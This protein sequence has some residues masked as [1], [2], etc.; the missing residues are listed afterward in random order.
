MTTLATQ[1]GCKLGVIG[2]GHWGKN[3]IRNAHQ[4]GVLVAICD[5]RPN[6]ALQADYPKAA[7]YTDWRDLLHHNRLDAVMIA[8]PSHTHFDIASQSLMLGKHVYV[9]KPMTTHSADAEALLALSEQENRVLMVGH[10]LMYH[11]AV[12]RLKQ[13]IK[14]GE[15]GDIRA[16]QSDRLS[17]NPN[18]PDASV[19]WDLAP[20]DISLVHYLLDDDQMTVDHVSGY[21]IGGDGRYDDVTVMMTLPASGAKAVIHTSW[22]HPAKQVQLI[23]HGTKASAVLNDTLTHDK[24]LLRYHNTQSQPVLDTPDCLSL[25][26]L[27]VECQHFIACVANN[28]TP[29]THAT[30]GLAVVRTLEQIAAHLG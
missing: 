13:L 8:T 7:W 25:E 17:Y 9:E 19:L 16:I 26:P 29:R 6:E 15:L 4:L 2:A 20:H 5:A 30:S 24:L 28:S 21:R 23:V 27:K 10:L 1:P 12:N 11:P 22:V 14:A 3:L 18:R